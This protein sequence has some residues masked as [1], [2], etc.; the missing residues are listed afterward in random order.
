MNEDCYFEIGHS[1][2]I[3]EDYALT[4]KI[5]DCLSYAIVCD[6]CSSSDTVDLG[7]RILAH[8]AKEYFCSGYAN[9]SSLPED[10]SAYDVGYSI[11]R[12]AEIHTKVLKLPN[13][14]LDA[15]LII[16]L[17][18]KD[19]AITFFYGDGG[20]L[21]KLDNAI[22]YQEVEFPSGA[23]FYLSYLLDLNRMRKY[24]EQFGKE[25]QT[26][27]YEVQKDELK[28]IDTKMHKEINTDEFFEAISGGSSPYEWIAVMSDGVRTY[29]TKDENGREQNVPLIDTI[30]KISDYKG[31]AG[32]FVERRM[33]R[34][35]QN[36]EKDGI[37]H[38]DDIS[39]STIYRGK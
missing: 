25:A 37:T 14:V 3:C 33:K 28:L 9:I 32:K 2:T 18:S 21:F 22:Y 8:C 7:A 4:G 31:F 1:H 17:A 39:V 36:C 11:I 20:L 26:N 12:M 23:P 34:M 16:T 15:T 6:G 19:N 27:Y 24:V 5:N 38:Y 30:R 10:M 35:R 29:Q 13:T